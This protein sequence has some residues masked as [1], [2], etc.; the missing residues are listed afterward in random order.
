MAIKKRFQNKPKKKNDERK[1]NSK[2][3]KREL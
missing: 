3:E 1:A 2:D